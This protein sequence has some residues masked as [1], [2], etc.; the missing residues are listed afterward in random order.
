VDVS[1]TN[2]A[3]RQPSDGAFAVMQRIRARRKSGQTIL[4]T[5]QRQIDERI[6]RELARSPMLREPLIDDGWCDGC[7]AEDFGRG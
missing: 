5:E 3:K 7:T 1:K 4:R 6:T 2:A